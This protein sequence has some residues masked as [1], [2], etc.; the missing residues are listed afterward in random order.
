MTVSVAQQ[1]AEFEAMPEQEYAPPDFVEWV[2]GEPLSEAE[3]EKQ[4]VHDIDQFYDDPLGYIMYAFP[5][6]EKGTELEEHDGPDQW[7]ADQMDRVRRGIRKDPEGTIR[8]AIASGH[9]IGKSA[10]VSWLILWAM[11][12]RPHLNGVITANTTTQLNTK[13]WR[14]LALWHKRAANRHWFKWTA[15]KFFHVEH[16]ETWFCSATPN[17]EHNSE[18]FAGLHGTHVLIIYDEASAIADQIYEVSEGA[19]T[20]PRAMWFCYG[21]P[22]RNTG[23]FRNMFAN[24]P[25]W[26]THQIDSRTCK[27]TNKSELEQQIAVYGEDSDFCRVRIKGQ[28][29]RAGSMQFISS[30]VCDTCMLYEAPYESFFQLPIVLGVDVARFGEDKS[31]IC[32]RQGRRVIELIKFREIDTMH[33]AAKVVAAIK[34]YQPAAT[35]VDVVGV[36]AGVVDRLRMLGHDIIEVNAGMKP[37]DNETYWNKRVE[38]WD[39][40]RQMMQEGMDIPNDADLRNALIGVEY[41]FND[42]EQMRL[43]RKQDMK[44]RGLESP[45][46]GDAIAYT[47]AEYI[48][49]WSANYFEPDDNFEPEAVAAEK[50]RDGLKGKPLADKIIAE[51]K[52]LPKPPMKP[53]AKAKPKRIK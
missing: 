17:T 52:L 7:Q 45:D 14:E 47:F 10:Q 39:R 48:G 49:D 22:T 30:E 3:F 19:M 11:S 29:P 44:K 53:P 21:N 6:G 50:K 8:E 4:L 20:D 28:F 32:V 16:P 25:R 42:K 1:I 23:K 46:E 12:T 33:L 26:V 13:T 34:K 51:K 43:E 9:G 15:T 18:A 41:G 5:W 27:M 40:M 31:V 2:E 38:M 36:G 35:F 37:D 24:D